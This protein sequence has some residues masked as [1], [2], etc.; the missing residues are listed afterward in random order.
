MFKFSTK[1]LSRQ[2]QW[3]SL[4]FS[5]WGLR[6]IALPVNNYPDMG[7][8]ISKEN[9]QQWSEISSRLQTTGINYCVLDVREWQGEQDLKSIK[10]LFLPNVGSLTG[11]QVLSLSSWIKRGGK[12]IVSG[13]TGKLATPEVQSTLK[14]VLGGYWGF[15]VTKPSTLIIKDEQLM[16]NKQELSTT[17]VGG[18]VIPANINT[19]T[20][21]VWMSEGKSPAV[22][23]NDNTTY[24]GWRWG[25]DNVTNADFDNA[26]LNTALQKYGINITGNPLTKS[27]T[28]PVVES[29]DGN[30]IARTNQNPSAVNNTN[31]STS[32]RQSNTSSN[33]PKSTQLNHNTNS[34]SRNLTSITGTK[35]QPTPQPVNRQNTSQVSNSTSERSP[36]I[37]ARTSSPTGISTKEI[38]NMMTELEELIYRVESTLI[39]SESK[40]LES[41]TSTSHVISQISHSNNQPNKFIFSDKDAHQALLNAKQLAQ[42][43]PELAQQNFPH[44]R[45]EW[46]NARRNLWDNYPVSR[47][48]AQPEVRAMWLDRGTIV[49][50]KSKAELAPIFDRMVEAG[51]NTVFF[52]TVNASYPVYPSRVA[53]EQNPLTRGWDPLQAAIELA[54]ERGI[55]LHAWVW[56]F[57][58][59]NQG[60][61]DI[62][63]QPQTYLGPVLSRNPDWVLKDQNGEVF[64]R[65]PG[66]KKAFYD[67]ANPEVRKYLLA[68]FQEIIDNYDVDGLQLDYIRYPFQDKITKQ[69][70][71]YTDVSR[72]LFKQSYGVDP[73]NIKPSSPQWEAWKGFRIQQVDSFVAEVAQ[74]LKQKRPDL[75]LSTAVFPMERKERLNTLQ[76]NWEEWLYSEWVDMMVLMTYALNTGSFAEKTKVVHDYSHNLSG[77]IIP[78][79]RL[80]N[81]PDT[82]TL[83][84]MQLLRNM[85][86]NGFALF[87]AENLDPSLQVIFKQTQGTNTSLK[88]PLPH[89]QPFASASA[90]YQNLRREWNFL[91]INNQI[92]VEPRYLKQW[93]LAVDSLSDRLNQLA[94]NPTPSNFQ[95]AQLE[96]VNFRKRLPQYLAKHTEKQP[97]QVQSWQNRLLTLENLL[98]YGQ[99]T[100]LANSLKNNTNAMK[101]EE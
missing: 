81:V 73:V 5:F 31:P 63:N 6:A 2:I 85:P 87:A 12:V 28:K 72:E 39:T 26:W 69:N 44:A 20:V 74:K 36:Q 52:E 76:Q 29:C 47:R 7:V 34:T 62:L 83:D 84:Q 99:R 1:L 77:L 40:Q 35:P 66:F 46:L 37:V 43:F 18:V 78:G 19:K 96:L 57:A 48:I 95:A 13:P 16:G 86:A 79:I 98:N 22:I 8:V 51:I 3:L 42:Q 38:N 9:A 25:V 41:S 100:V 11:E 15:P 59:A 60:H 89:R 97:L 80:L 10:V 17:L 49:K 91:L 4:L 58:G 90:R 33:P 70:F 45:Q 24:F 71:G 54:H 92:L 27:Q 53:P 32:N 101:N 55:E 30:Q 82:E 68:L 61:N 50:A 93:S 75:I 67:P 21:A 94:E 23:Q 14:N 88:E 65:T 64:N 56:V